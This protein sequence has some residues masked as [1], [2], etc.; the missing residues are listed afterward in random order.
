MAVRPMYFTSVLEVHKVVCASKYGRGAGAAAA[1][2]AQTL[3]WH[4]KIKCMRKRRRENRPKGTWD[5]AV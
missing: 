5:T 4:H 1:G 2:S 3:E